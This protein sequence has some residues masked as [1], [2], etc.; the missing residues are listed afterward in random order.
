VGSQ[1]ESSFASSGEQALRLAAQQPFDVIVSDMRMPK[2]NGAQLLNEVM[3]RYPSMVR[4]ILS[5]YPEEEV[6]MQCVGT[7]HQFL[8]KPFDLT[9]LKAALNRIFHLKARLQSKEIQA[10]LARIESLPSIPSVYF[11][12]QEVLQSPDCPVEDIGRIVATDPGLTMKLLQLVNSAFFGFARNVSNV[13]EAIM[14]LGTGRLRALTLVPHLFSAF[15]TTSGEVFSLEKVWHHSL[16]VAESARKIATL[17]RAGEK[18]REQAFTA[19]LLHDV[20]KLVLAENLAHWYFELLTQAQMQKRPLI[21]LEQERFHVT[22]ADAG[23]YLLDLW[24]LPTPLV[25]AVA[26]HHEPSKA[27]EVAFSPLTAVYV[28]NELEG[29]GD[30]AATEA[31]LERLDMDYLGHF[32][33]SYR[34]KIWL[35]ELKSASKEPVG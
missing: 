9:T 21:E 28:A 6:V 1:W 30:G 10:L 20:G 31:V 7:V 11:K 25:E 12:L 33:S 26:L 2:M 19:G 23:A 14:L 29:S 4:L 18:T 32:G 22:H 5:G 17:E 15:K 24:G 8:A 34:V 35:D 27:S 3:K 16:R 13:E